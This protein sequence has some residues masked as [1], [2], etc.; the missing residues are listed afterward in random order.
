MLSVDWHPNNV[1]LAAGSADM[2][3]RV[4]SAYIKDVDKKYVSTALSVVRL[5]IISTGLHPR[6]G[7]RSYPSTPYAV[8][9]AALLVAGYTQSASPHPAM[10]LPLLVSTIP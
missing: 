4:F 8:N 2:K 9:T 6:F 1:L 7:A 5:L 10:F 3:A